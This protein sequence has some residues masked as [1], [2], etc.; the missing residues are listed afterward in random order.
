MKPYVIKQGDYM[1]KLG[2]TLGFDADAVWNDGKNKELKKARKNPNML[3]PGDILF[4]PDEPRK[5][6]AL[7]KETDNSYVATVPKISVSVIV[8][9]D[10]EPIKDEKYQLRGL[11]DETEYQTDSDGRVEFKAPVHVREVELY[12]PERELTM[13]VGIGDLDPIDTDSG[14]RM[15]LT[16]LGFYGPKVSGEDQYVERED[17]QLAGAVAAFQAS[18][19]LTVN[20]ILDD[21]T[22]DALV[23]A[24]GS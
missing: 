18:V 24:H 19:G 12:F 11:D 13:K 17:A 1:A 22:R 4:V 23:E 20:G 5:G 2:H 3:V 14:V 15:R 7:E 21:E 8:T 16:H 9:E 6:L 10:D